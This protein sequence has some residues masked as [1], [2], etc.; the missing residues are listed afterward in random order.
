MTARKRHVH[1]LP[2]AMLGPITNQATAD[3]FLDAVVREGLAFHADDDPLDALSGT[4]LT[5]AA[6]R[7]LGERVMRAGAYSGCDVHQAQINAASRVEDRE[8]DR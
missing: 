8:L 1:D 4:D 7:W 3:A 6:M 2:A 5:E